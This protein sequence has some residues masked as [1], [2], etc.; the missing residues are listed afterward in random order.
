MDGNGTY[1]RPHKAL[2]SLSTTPTPKESSGEQEDSR[3]RCSGKEVKLWH[4]Q[5]GMHKKITPNMAVNFV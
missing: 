1:T 5:D 4:L 3:Q 2:V